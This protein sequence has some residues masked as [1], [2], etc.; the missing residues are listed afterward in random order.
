EKV[1]TIEELEYCQKL[2]FD[3]FQGYYLCKPNIV[4]GK[5]M[6]TSRLVVVN[7]IARIQDPEA[8]FK[9]LEELIAQ[10]STLT[11]KLI[12]LVNSAYYS[13]ANEVKSIGQAISLIG[14]D[15]LRG[16]LMLVLMAS[17]DNKPHELTM[18]GLLRARFC[19]MLARAKGVKV[20]DQYFMI[21]LLSIM[22]AL[23][24]MPIDQVVIGLNLS[25]D[26]VEALLNRKG[27]PGSILSLVIAYE[28]GD[29]EKMMM[30]GLRPEAISDS[31]IKSLK[32]A[33]TLGDSLR[34]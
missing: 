9:K 4:Q 3:F 19:E 25:D 8:N 28:Q 32:W 11:Y 21:G 26:I 1:E 14:T 22:D 20:T 29:M 24:D 17:I 31:Y 10:D 7:A 12:R 34:N 30:L 5:R 23:L 6:D 16:W 27:L 2:G 18:I 15:N 13:T 33:S